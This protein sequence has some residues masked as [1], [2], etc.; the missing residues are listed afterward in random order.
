MRTYKQIMQRLML[1]LA[2]MMCVTVVMAGDYKALA[3][4][5]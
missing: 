3:N 2:M 4:W 1:V 5:N